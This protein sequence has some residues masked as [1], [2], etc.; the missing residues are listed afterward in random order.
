M[1]KIVEI[2]RPRGAHWVGDGFPVRTLFSYDA[3]PE[4]LSPF[5]LFDYAGPHVFAPSMTPRGVGRHPHRGFETVTI[6]Y[7]GEVAHRDSA[8]GG[9]VIGPG[10]VQWMTAA[11]G[12]IH[13]EFHSKG[14]TKSGGP[15]RMVQ[16]WVNLPARD[17]MKPPAYQAIASA[18]IP[19]VEF[20]GGRARVI[21][22]EFR[23]TRGP[24][25]TF[26]PVNL[27][28]VRLKRDGE[29]RL[30]LPEGHNSMIAVLSGRAT[31]DGAEYAGE[32]E[33]IRFEREGSEVLVRADADSMLLVLAGEPI[34]E[35]VAGYGPF[36]M[37]TPA[38]IRQA[39][40]DYESGRFG[41][42]GA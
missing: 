1:K 10:D 33:V 19:V 34:D 29:A 9:G 18:E 32:A 24:A 27:W 25:R 7:D 2:L 39:I 8:G 28:D 26:T 12:I 41:A 13:E 30:D 17:K 16:L 23:G 15:F 42:F 21:A 11:G 5:L 31:F 38:E 40:D 14:F 36:V 3:D 22:G 20:D 6:V 4:K 35:P 37:N